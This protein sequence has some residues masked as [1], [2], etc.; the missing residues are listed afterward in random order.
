MNAEEREPI[1]AL[2]AWL[3]NESAA[4]SN[5]ANGIDMELELDTKGPARHP[6]S[7]PCLLLDDNQMYVGL[8]VFWLCERCED[9]LT[10]G[11]GKVLQCVMRVFFIVLV[12]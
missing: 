5:A 11:Q 7:F 6:T 10:R 9:S 3:A 12:L 8:H 2:D 4:D 1:N